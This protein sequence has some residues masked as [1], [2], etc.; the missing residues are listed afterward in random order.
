MNKLVILKNSKMFQN[1]QSSEHIQQI[2]R[3]KD[4]NH[5]FL[6]VEKEK[7]FNKIQKAFMIKA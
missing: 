6:S 7:D 1:I 5:M 4:K 3:I 2:N